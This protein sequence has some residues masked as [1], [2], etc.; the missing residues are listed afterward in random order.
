MGKSEGTTYGLRN[1]ASR[2]ANIMMRVRSWR[3]G[4]LELRIVVFWLRHALLDSPSGRLPLMDV[5]NLK[6]NMILPNNN[7]AIIDLQS[8]CHLD[9][10]SSTE[11]RLHIIIITSPPVRPVN[12]DSNRM[13]SIF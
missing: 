10:R 9:S 11:R 12:D 6:Y 8:L 7:I 1:F 3:D 13:G 5:I 2:A 4:S